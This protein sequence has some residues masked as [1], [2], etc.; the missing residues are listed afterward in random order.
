MPGEPMTNST[1][2]QRGQRSRRPW[3]PS[4]LLLAQFLTI[5]PVLLIVLADEQQRRASEGYL[6][7]LDGLDRLSFAIA[8]LENAPT[9]STSKDRAPAAVT[10]WRQQYSD[11]RSELDRMLSASASAP[12]IRE[13]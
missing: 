5:T 12:Q 13:I 7:V 1:V 9:P 6:T 3:L 2:S 4:L 11:A 8:D 10:E